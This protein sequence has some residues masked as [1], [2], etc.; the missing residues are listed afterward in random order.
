MLPKI[1]AKTIFE[2]FGSVVDKINSHIK[3]LSGR[4][5]CL[6]YGF[7]KVYFSPRVNWIYN[8]ELIHIGKGSRFGRSAVITAWTKFGNQVFN[9][10]I[11]I[12][13][14][15]SFNDYIHITSINRIV[16]GSNV[17]TGRWVTITDNSHGSTEMSDLVYPPLLRPLY[18]KG[19]VV[20]GKNVWIGDKVT[21]LPGVSIGDGSVIA[22]NSVVTKSIPPYSIAAG[23]PAKIIKQNTNNE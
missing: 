3:G 23:I 22:A 5:I 15:C 16:I 11:E 2:W 4:W 19:Q 20:I 17:L 1:S 18:S 7:E 12:G 10:S 13:E 9:P 21:I 8:A 6:K 14:G